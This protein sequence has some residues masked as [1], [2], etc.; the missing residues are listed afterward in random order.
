MSAFGHS[1]HWARD[2]DLRIGTNIGKSASLGEPSPIKIHGDLPEPGEASTLP[3][4][5]EDEAK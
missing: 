4:D 2:R 3:M 1:G 5:V